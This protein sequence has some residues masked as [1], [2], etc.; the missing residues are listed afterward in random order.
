MAYMCTWITADVRNEG[1][2]HV[3]NP[4]RKNVNQRKWFINVLRTL[5]VIATAKIARIS[6][7]RLG[8]IPEGPS[9]NHL[10]LL[11][12]QRD[13]HFEELPDRSPPNYTNTGPLHLEI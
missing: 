5:P 12:S 13:G 8:N 4:K 6:P 3:Q 9:Y 11:I 7:N 1:R 2:S 10:P